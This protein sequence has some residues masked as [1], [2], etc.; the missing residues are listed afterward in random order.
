MAEVTARLPEN[1]SGCRNLTP[2]CISVVFSC[3]LSRSIY[4]QLHYIQIKAELTDNTPK[5]HSVQWCLACL[6]PPPRRKYN[7]VQN[8]SAPPPPPPASSCRLF[9]RPQWGTSA[10]WASLHR[11]RWPPAD[12][13][14]WPPSPV[15]GQL[16]QN[17]SWGGK[18]KQTFRQSFR[19]QCSQFEKL[20]ANTNHFMRNMSSPVE[21]VA[22]MI[23]SGA[24]PRAKPLSFSVWGANGTKC[25]HEHGALKTVSAVWNFMTKTSENVQSKTLKRSVYSWLKHQIRT[26]EKPK[27]LV[28]S[29]RIIIKSAA[30]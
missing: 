4:I 11:R 16:R 24:S 19:R 3:V 14:R 2:L 25:Q 17:F 30:D 9:S 5:D 18:K 13:S 22:P 6:C 21:S 28:V 1:S 12:T 27:R 20:G 26:I 8:Y 15:P 7:E 10:K 29:E 23:L